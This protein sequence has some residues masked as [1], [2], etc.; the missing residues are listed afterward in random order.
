LSDPDKKDEKNKIFFNGN[1]TGSP[2]WGF[3][4]YCLQV[5]PVVPLSRLKKGK[6][7]GFGFFTGQRANGPTEQGIQPKNII[8]YF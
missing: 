2:V 8:C 6:M 1:L 7:S 5:E 3:N 4:C